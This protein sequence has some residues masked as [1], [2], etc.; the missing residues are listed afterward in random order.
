MGKKKKDDNA[1]VSFRALVG[2]QFLARFTYHEIGHAFAWFVCHGNIDNIAEI[3]IVEAATKKKK[4]MSNLEYIKNIANF[5][6]GGFNF[7]FDELCYAIGGGLCEAMFV[8]NYIEKINKNLDYE[9]PIKGMEEDMESVGSILTYLGVKDEKEVSAFLKVA[10]RRLFIPFLVNADKI[11][12]LANMVIKNNK[13]VLYEK[14]FNDVFD[15]SKFE[16]ERNE[17]MMY[18]AEL[19]DG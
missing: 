6:N 3:N 14:D 18:L 15:M 7:A 17:A 19:M 2:E 10:I 16:D 8:D 5:A 11:I 12:L 13:S 9:F 4:Y 1:I